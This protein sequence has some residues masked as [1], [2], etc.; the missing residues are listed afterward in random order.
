MNNEG[1]V[2]NRF[3]AAREALREILAEAGL[4]SLADVP[5]EDHRGRAWGIAQGTPYVQ[6]AHGE[7]WN[8]TGQTAD[9]D[10]L[11][12]V[13]GLVFHASHFADELFV[14]DANPRDDAALSESLKAHGAR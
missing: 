13:D 3:L 1:D 11:P 2:L 4:A 5:I 10:R 6:F 12:V 8:S 9:E 7:Q 14:F